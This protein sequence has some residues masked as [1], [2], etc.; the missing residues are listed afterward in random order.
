MTGY[1]DERSLLSDVFTAPPFTVSRSASEEY[2]RP[3]FEVEQQ[4]ATEDPAVISFDP[5]PALC[6]PQSCSARD[7]DEIFY[8]D[9]THLSPTGAMRLVS[10][11]RSAILAASDAAQTPAGQPSAP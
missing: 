1:V 7:G 4:L 11:L 5:N 3:A 6:G 9:Q 8:E 10:G 2:R